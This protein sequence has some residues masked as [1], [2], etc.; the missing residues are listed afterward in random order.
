AKKA[1]DY[2]PP[3]LA[4]KAVVHEHC[5]HKSMLDKSAEKQLLDALGLDYELLDSGCCGMAGAFGFEKRHYDISIKIGERV[6]L[7]KVREAAKD[8]IIIADGFSCREQ[9]AQT[10]D[11]RALHIAQ[12]MQIALRDGLGGLAGEYPEKRALKET[13]HRKSRSVLTAP[14]LV[15]TTWLVGGF[16]VWMLKKAASR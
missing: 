3:K 8:A 9:I 4:R 15:A 16:L 7:P 2:K 14:A 6:L 5:H 12:V 13:N 10:T 1:P 11:R